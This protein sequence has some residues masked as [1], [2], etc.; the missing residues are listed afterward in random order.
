MS[1]KTVE[2]QRDNLIGVMLSVAKNC[3]NV[4]PDRLCETI[5]EAMAITAGYLDGD[6]VV[7][8][9]F[10][11][12]RGLAHRGYEWNRS[13]GCV[14][15]DMKKSVP[16]SDLKDALACFSQ[17]HLY[18]RNS[19]S[20]TGSAECAYHAYFAGGQEG[21]IAV[22]AAGRKKKWQSDETAAFEVFCEIIIS[23]IERL[24][25]E[26]R[27]EEKNRT[28][29]LILN[30]LRDEVSLLDRD[31]RILMAN[32]S[33]AEQFNRPLEELIGK[34]IR[35]FVHQEHNEFHSQS[36]NKIREV[37]DTGIAAEL[38][39][40]Q[41]GR[42][43]RSRFY[44]VIE[45][46]RV[47][48]V[49]KITTDI[50]DEVRLEQETVKNAVL[51]KEAD[52]LREKERELLEILDTAADGSNIND[53]KAGAGEYSE[54]WLRRI[55]GESVPKTELSQYF[56]S[57]IHPEDRARANK[58]RHDAEASGKQRFSTVFRVKMADGRYCWTLV[59]GKLIFDENGEPS[60]YYGTLTDISEIKKNEEALRASEN[61]SK[62]LV[63]ELEKVREDL[64][65]EVDALRRLHLI[66]SV[67]L[68]L[69]DLAYIYDEILDAAISITHA[70][71]GCM[72]VYDEQ[73]NCLKIATH[74]GLSDETVK[75]IA[76]IPSGRLISGI[77]LEKKARV[78]STNLGDAS[79]NGSDFTLADKEKI[80]CGQSTPIISCTGKIYGMLNTFYTGKH[81]FDER[82][83][84]FLDLLARQAA[85]FIERKR[86]EVAL[87]NSEKNAND[88]VE[89]LQKMD[90][91]KDDF[92]NHLAHE[93]RNPLATIIAA[94]SLIDISD[95]KTEINETNAILRNETRQ[96]N[97]LIDDLL[98]ATR[99]STNKVKIR[100]K[101]INLNETLQ[102][103]AR[104]FG[105]QFNQKH[106]RFITDVGAPA[107]FLHA[108][109]S[110]IM[111]IVENLLMNALT[112]T[113]E[114][115]TVA[116]SLRREREN[117]VIRVEDN[118]IGISPE[119]LPK[120]FNAFYQA[121]NAPN[122]F[123]SGLGLG[124]SVVKGMTELH[125]G[126]VSAYSTGIGHGS[127]FSV[128][129][130]IHGNPA[131]VDLDE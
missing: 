100:K 104:N 85:D 61:R 79:Q 22:S 67:Y 125:E 10:D 45:K 103:S 54:K 72:Q 2:C 70:D 111:Q 107:I 59:R 95:D 87:E 34:K 82:E 64:T 120:L 57:L 30:A 126:T 66:S 110:R 89:T 71:K 86:D 3:I 17:G 124:L 9:R 117:A 84:R 115:G 29:S 99:I 56:E 108:D 63:A 68:M 80:R 83:L 6:R 90:R 119:E 31:G 46:G 121:E 101:Y 102:S 40:L 44:P 97:R 41:E 129:L 14:C 93:L 74:R 27:F 55:G 58:E 18:V 35:Q 98:D 128:T 23:M 49:T 33:F 50:T 73:E 112:Y 114:G 75:N 130:P 51:A 96:L 38:K 39:C 65:K 62:L 122:R 81:D 5:G 43:V 32:R 25:E 8:Y 15:R 7:S 20:E 12:E 16:L 118:G 91:S 127:T 60:K 113:D 92:I 69:N 52:L 94:I 48:A 47:A 36:K 19:L 21:M 42:W 28:T 1:E 123:N 26:S 78:I 11:F 109:P 37:F 77:A 131:D 116:L 105:P 106:I 76:I 24:N 13:E 4:P 88:L 53:F